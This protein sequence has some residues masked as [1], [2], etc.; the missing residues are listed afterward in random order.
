ME[1]LG[2]NCCSYTASPIPSTNSQAA[3]TTF[4]SNFARAMEPAPAGCLNTIP[5]FWVRGALVMYRPRA[6]SSR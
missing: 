1:K 4:S 3:S 6:L 2:W 5:L